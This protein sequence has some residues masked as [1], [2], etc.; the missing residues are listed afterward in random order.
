MSKFSN[1][2]LSKLT[3]IEKKFNNQNYKDNFFEELNSTQK[4]QSKL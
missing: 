3:K 4:K 2:N 1:N